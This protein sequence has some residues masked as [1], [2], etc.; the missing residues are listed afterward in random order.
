M[1]QGK[2]TA[3]LE[4]IEELSCI[5][6]LVLMLIVTFAQILFRYVLGTPL[7]WSEEFARLLFIWLNLIGAGIAI[8]YK[9]HVSFDLVTSRIKNKFRVAIE[10]CMNLIIIA[11]LIGIL[12]P[13]IKYVQFMNTIPSAAL[14]WPMGVFYLGMPLA[15]VFI[16]VTLINQMLMSIQEIMTVKE[17]DE[18]VK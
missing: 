13:S 16:S 2:L 18:V 5:L 11:S 15:I 12:I 8:R 14:E 4:R 6:L 10:I 9:A 3:V 17:G 7:T 1:K